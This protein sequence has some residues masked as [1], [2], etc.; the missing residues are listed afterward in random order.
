[1]SDPLAG[2]AYRALARLGVGGSAEVYEADHVALRKRVVVKVLR[3]ELAQSLVH[4]ERMRVE[5]QTLARLAHPNLATV[6]DSG[7][8]ASGR[9]FFVMEYEDG[10]TLLDEVRARDHLPV[11]EAVAL[12]QQLLAGLSAAHAVGVIHRDIKL[13]NLFLCAPR[14]GHRT[15]KILDF[16][17]AKVLP[18]ADASRAPMPVA[19]QTLEEIP[20]G[21]PRFLSPEQALCLPVDERTDV[22]GAGMVL[23]ELLVGRDPFFHVDGYIE[24]LQAHVSQD[25]F[26]PSCLSP[27]ALEGAVDDVVLGALAKRPDDRYATAAEFSAALGMLGCFRR[28]RAADQPGRVSY[29]RD[30][31]EAD[32]MGAMNEAPAL[33]LGSVFHE[34]RVVRLLGQGLH[35]QVFE[36]A[37]L[38]TGQAFALKVMRLEDRND[39]KKV[40]RA[41]TTAKGAYTIQHAN[42]VRVHNLS[43]EPDG[44]VWM[45]ME[46]L[47]GRPL[48][49]ILTPGRP[50]SPLFALNVAI[51]IAWGLDAAHEVGI[52]HRDIKP[53]NVFIT[54]EGVVKIV[55]FSIAKVIPAG[56]QTTQ[57]GYGVG[58]AAYMAPDT[59]KGGEPDARFDVY[60]LGIVLWEML[61]GYHPFHDAA[62]DVNEIIRRQAFVELGPLSLLLHLPEYLDVLIRRATAKDP[63]QRFFSVAQMAKEMAHVR[64]QLQEDAEAEKIVLRRAP[65]GEPTL[66]NPLAHRENR[67]A[68]VPESEPAPPMPRERV[69]VATRTAPHALAATLPLPSASPSAVARVAPPAPRRRRARTTTVLVALVVIASALTIAVALRAVVVH[70]APAPVAA[71]PQV[72]E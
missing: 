28:N 67:S 42:V 12:V 32:R 26:P 4:L 57:R 39:A 40:Q 59:I 33:A 64:D 21:T 72:G 1:M 51:E 50:C 48:A 46:L 43:C 56:I 35:G 13:E 69:V 29:R 58:T 65:P 19:I 54:A 47:S 37:H 34:Y 49:R 25:P 14:D 7:T 8:T 52:I 3:A 45:L 62:G 31:G 20:L 6:F 41:L 63:N 38:H 15:L 10:R 53:D 27:Q 44:M 2:S 68:R 60:S 9:P 71:P 24:L 5:A 17:I 36:V 18:D 22:Y 30:R 11:A 61:A 23:Y 70:G 16:G 66:R 55:D